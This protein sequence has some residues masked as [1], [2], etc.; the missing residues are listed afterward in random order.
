MK[1]SMRDWKSLFCREKA[2]YDLFF[3]IILSAVFILT[4]NTHFTGGVWG[5]I[6]ENYINDP[7]WINVPIQ[8]SFEMNLQRVSRQ[9]TPPSSDVP[10]Q[11]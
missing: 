8:K 7:T 3:S 9:K 1:E 4:I 11:E 10:C 2:A 5:T 6:E